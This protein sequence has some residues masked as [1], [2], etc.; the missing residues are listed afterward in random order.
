MDFSVFKRGQ[1]NNLHQ[2]NAHRPA[3]GS[4]LLVQVS[5][6]GTSVQGDIYESFLLDIQ[7]SK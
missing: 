7:M 4:S 2:T 3:R 5:N 1:I 6:L